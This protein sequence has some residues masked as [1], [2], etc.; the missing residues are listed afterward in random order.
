MTPSIIKA[1]HPHETQ[2]WGRHTVKLQHSLHRHSLFT[3][4]SLAQL[5]DLLPTE[6]IAINTMAA[7]GHALQSW[8][9]CE[10]GSLSG[11]DIL[12]LVRR[13]RLWI[14]MTK[15]ELVDPRFADLLEGIY[16]EL[17][18]SF[19]GFRTWKRSVGLLVSSPSA[20]V[21]YHADVPG[22]ALWQLRGRKRI[23]IYPAEEPF[24]PPR[25]IENIVRGVTEEE[26]AYHPWYDQFAEVHTLDAGDVIHW[27][28]N[29]PHRVVNENEINV[30]LTT[31]HW[32]DEIRRSY[33]MNY[34]NGIL[35]RE[36]GIAPQSR[37]ISGAAFWSK[38][39]LTALW[40]ASGAHRRASFRRSFRYRLD[41]ASQTGVS[42][43]H[44]PAE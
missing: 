4:E 16:S 2:L 1:P 9:Y 11:V 34:G 5:I 33:A 42:L 44:A 25:D 40:R 17:G 41:A 29:G 7:Q 31:E 30:S 37:A 12:N 32:T 22:Q 19:S 39:A 10:R 15:L 36:F 18:A 24:L 27:K 8:S 43:L 3:D 6:R 35:R 13:G 28:L 26:F 23:Y 38:V 20:Q 14:N 21:F